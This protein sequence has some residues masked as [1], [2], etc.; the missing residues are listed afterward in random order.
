MGFV[1]AFFVL[2]S[3]QQLL[4]QCI[5]LMLQEKVSNVLLS[6]GALPV[7]REE[8]KSFEFGEKII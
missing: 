3:E 7:Y 6:L 2:Y 4:L 1:S 8:T 5:G